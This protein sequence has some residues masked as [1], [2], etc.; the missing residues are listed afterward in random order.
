MKIILRGKENQNAY[1]FNGKQ[2]DTTVRHQNDQIQNTTRPGAAEGVEQ[3]ELLSIAGGD[4]ERHCRFGGRAG[5]LRER[6]MLFDAHSPAVTCLGIYPKSWSF[7]AKNW[8]QPR[9]SLVGEWINRL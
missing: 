7:I 8:K 3:Q 2:Q 1:I 5:L 4:T 6:S 9:C